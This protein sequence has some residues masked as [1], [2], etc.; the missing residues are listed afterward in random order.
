MNNSQKRHGN[1]EWSIESRTD[2]PGTAR[3]VSILQ[4][5]DTPLSASFGN[6]LFPAGSQA[7]W[8]NAIIDRGGEGGDKCRALHDIR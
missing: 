5:L 6:C 4:S 2:L 7:F 8:H 1:R 3:G